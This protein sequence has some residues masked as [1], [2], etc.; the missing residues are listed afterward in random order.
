MTRLSGLVGEMEL[1]E[2]KRCSRESELLGILSRP[3]LTA[4]T[5]EDAAEDVWLRMPK[6]VYDL[7]S[8]FED[9]LFEEP[10]TAATAEEAAEDV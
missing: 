9:S 2:G 8:P 1:L 7:L 5:A 4:A 10:R 6:P 3:P